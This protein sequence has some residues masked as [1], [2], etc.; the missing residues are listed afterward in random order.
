[1][2]NLITGKRFAVLQVEKTQVVMFKEDFL[3]LLECAGDDRDLPIAVDS[4]QAH[5]IALHIQGRAFP[6]PLTHDLLKQVIELSGCILERVEIHDL[7]SDGA[8]DEGGTFYARLLVSLPGEKEP[9]VIDARPSDAISLALRCSAGIYVEES[10]MEKAGI[11]IGEGNIT[12][13]PNPEQAQE[14]PTPVQ[15]L[16][17][18]LEDAIRDERYEDAASLRDQ[19]THLKKKTSASN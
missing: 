18:D 15:K 16:E 5:A 8:V 19:I 10:V 2:E 6:R 7:R 9:R 13:S 4:G 11:L 1:V 12:E 17:Q 14:Q 3:V